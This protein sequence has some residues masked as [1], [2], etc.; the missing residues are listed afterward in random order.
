MSNINRDIPVEL[1]VEHEQE[2]KHA[3]NQLAA[4]Q[5][6]HDFA[7]NI[8]V[9]AAES[10][11]GRVRPR[12]RELAM[13]LTACCAAAVALTLITAQVSP[14]FASLVGSIPGFS[15]ASDWLT[16]LRKSDGVQ[17]A[18]S[19]QYQPSAPVVQ[20]LGDTTVGLS[21]VYL[22]S[23]KLVY[24]VFVR[25][26]RIKRNIIT[27]SDGSLGVDGKAVG[28]YVKS[29]D[30]PG[31]GSGILKIVHDEHTGE[32][33]MV[34]PTM[35]E[36]TP[37][38]VASFLNTNPTKLSFVF[39]EPQQGKELPEKHIL[40]V[41][42]DKS[43]W[44]EDKIYPQQQ[45]VKVTGNP[46]IQTIDVQ[47]VKV[48]PMNT[49]VTLHLN[50][51]GD[52]ILDLDWND[53]SVQLTDNKGNAYQL[54]TYRDVDEK[55][56]RMGSDTIKLVFASSPYFDKEVSRLALKIGHVKLT[57]IKSFPLSLD[58]HIPKILHFKD[59]EMLLTK[60]RYEDGFL[61][62]NIKQNPDNPMS[63][64]FN[65]PAFD[66]KVYKSHA[67]YQKLFVGNLDKEGWSKNKLR[68]EEG[69]GEYEVSVMAPK[70]SSYEIE[71]MNAPSEAEKVQ[72]NKTIELN[73][74][75]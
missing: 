36:L 22:T 33:I 26:D 29:L 48:T 59:K 17:N 21:D 60:A 53:L 61:K 20:Q 45:S 30:F 15:V 41:K 64:Y 18:N 35:T 56:G 74:E 43:Q 42:F 6:L 23:D 55:S 66:A 2:L 69:K 52:H 38:E 72:I 25:S 51:P 10:K 73:L 65:I 62:L 40:N 47:E 3:L 75:K 58:E 1:P 11:T 32:P 71:M 9:H 4:P 50:S 5:K 7:K 14:A 44:K 67:L 31:Y 54:D 24:K 27:N 39:Y 16:S 34:I 37:Q 57:E 8:S 68:I 63:I 49:Y 28:Y 19:H 12:I 46:E 13:V 70:Q